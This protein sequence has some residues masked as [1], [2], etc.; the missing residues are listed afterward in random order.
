IHEDVCKNGYNARLG[1]FVQ[2]YGSKEV[3]ASLLMI[4]KVGF[5]PGSDERVK[6]TV[7]AIER[8]LL[9]NG[10]VL[11]YRTDKVEDG[12]PPGEGV[13]LAC[14]FWLADNYMHIG[15]RQKAKQ[16]FEKLLKL[17]ND[18]GLLAEEYDPKGKRHL[19]NF[20]Q[21]F[22]HIALI[23]TAFE[24]SSGALSRSSKRRKSA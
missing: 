2:H 18:V 9:K 3:D 6:G 22:S 12:L 23:N 8:Q 17:Q 13:F 19:G 4:A 15:K 21:A 24:L 10:L 11:R 5:L 20:P 14:S 7:R 16:L 1:S